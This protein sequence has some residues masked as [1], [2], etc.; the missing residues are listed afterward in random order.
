MQIKV[1]SPGTSDW[2]AA[3]HIVRDKYRRAFEADVQ[4]NPD[5][6]VVCFAPG[7]NGTEPAAM[8][9]AGVT[10]S[11]TRALFSERYLDLP[12]HMAIQ[13]AEGL[14]SLQRDS[15][16]EIGSLASAGQRAGAELVRL[17]P[18]LCWCLGK[19]YILCTATRPL[20]KSLTG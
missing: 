7:A 4:P 17:L 11:S 3:V 9:C 12:A 18:L 14:E 19:R 8:A 13:H 10:W 6:F 5:R 20:R 15:V 2:E 1:T 16:V